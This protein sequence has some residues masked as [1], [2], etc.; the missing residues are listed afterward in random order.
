M[1]ELYEV[2]D[3]F[4]IIESN[5]TFTGRPKEFMFQKNKDRFKWASAKT[6]YKALYL[7]PLNG[8]DPF[9]LERLQRQAMDALIKS[10]RL[11]TGDKIIMADVD[12]IPS[13]HTISLLKS[14]QSPNVHLQLRNYMY[15]FEF[16]VDMNS[17]RAKVVS[18]PFAY[19]HSRIPSLSL[20]ADSGW[21]CSFCF[22]ALRDFVF[23]MQAY[24]HADRVHSP[25]VLDL[26]R[27]QR[28]V[29]E[30]GDIFDMVPEAHTFGDLIRNM[31]VE[32]GKSAVGVPWWVLKQKERFAYLLPGGCIRKQG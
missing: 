16:H 30:G 10:Q 2:V 6:N 15:S 9:I 25:A 13:Q 7:P 3:Y 4:L 1:K 18:F 29:C 26:D 21:H 27:I 11:S 12:E 14:C 31:N 28:K 32:K 20:L 19:T 24:S 5:S 23:K 8:R 22:P 17:W